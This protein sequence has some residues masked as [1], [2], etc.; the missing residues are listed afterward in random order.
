MGSSFCANGRS[1]IPTDSCSKYTDKIKA[2]KALSDGSV[3]DHEHLP[4]L[5]NPDLLADARKLVFDM[6]CEE[7]RSIASIQTIAGT[8]A[9]H[10]GALLLAKTCRPRTVWIS[11]PSWINHQEIWTLVDDGIE[12]QTYP[13]FDSNTF[14]IDFEGM[15]ETLRSRAA[16][17]DVVV[18]HGCAHN[19]TG[20]DLTRDQ[21]QIVAD[22]CIQKRLVPLF[23]LA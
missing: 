12:R 1:Q 16:M 2:K 11:N 23:D 14:S 6:T 18:L 17:G 4:L 8:G 15:T 19:P 13:Y 10:L 7:E 3:D 21:W 9:N 20:L 5:G 22:I